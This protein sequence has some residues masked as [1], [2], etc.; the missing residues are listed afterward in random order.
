MREENSE[1]NNEEIAEKRR[2]TDGEDEGKAKTSAA[3]L[4]CT[5]GAAI[6][7]GEGRREKGWKEKI[8]HGESERGSAVCARD[9]FDARREWKRE[10]EKKKR[11]T[12]G[13]RNCGYIP[14]V[15]P[16]FLSPPRSSLELFS[17][18]FT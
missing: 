8:M 3:S 17:K 9:T 5:P 1:E 4:L 7:R 13:T 18:R 12:G 15:A 14:F 6:Q 11:S 16:P 2:R 10:N